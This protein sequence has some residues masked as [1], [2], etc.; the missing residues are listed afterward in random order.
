MIMTIVFAFW[1]DRAKQRSPFIMAGF[2]I[3]AAGFIGQLAIPHTR[4]P[5]LTYGFLFPVA[6]GLYC[7][8]IHIVCWTGKHN[9]TVT[10]QSSISD[11]TT[12]NNLAP[13]S[14]RAVGMGLLISVGNLGGIAGSN[15]Y[16]ATQAPKYPTGFGTGL[17]MSIAAIV[18]AYVLRRACDRENKARR[19]MLDEEGEQA[20]RARYSEQELLDMG[21][22]SPFFIYTL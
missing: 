7:P 18:M 6:A 14:K 1:S 3:A 13:S 5:G 16:I 20:V 17:G 19:K 4:L 15:I 21:D 11:K 2:S 10:L 8:F 12:A 9:R 22:K